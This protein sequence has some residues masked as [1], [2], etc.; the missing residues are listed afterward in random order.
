MISHKKSHRIDINLIGDFYVWR[1]DNKILYIQINNNQLLKINLSNV[2]NNNV[3]SI[4]KND[5][6]YKFYVTS[7]AVKK[8]IDQAIIF[9]WKPFKKDKVFSLQYNSNGDLEICN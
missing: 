4:N 7:S 6:K 2:I 5:K 9:G 3:V 1:F 8:L